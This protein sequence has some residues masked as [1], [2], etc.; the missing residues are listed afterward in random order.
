MSHFF[1]FQ[2]I[3]AV[4]DLPYLEKIDVAVPTNL[5]CGNCSEDAVERLHELGGKSPQGYVGLPWPPRSHVRAIARYPHS[6]SFDRTG[7]A[8]I[9]TTSG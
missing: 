4:L 7:E 5:K 6:Q 9:R 8:I 3:R 2:Q 1:E